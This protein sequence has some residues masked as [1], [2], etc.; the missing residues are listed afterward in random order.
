MTFPTPLPGMPT[1]A[2]PAGKTPMEIAQE[3]ADA[4]P[5][6][7][8]ASAPRWRLRNARSRPPTWPPAVRMK[9]PSWPSSALLK[10]TRANA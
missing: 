2:Y 3:L 5:P 10:R 7:K 1:P 9:P 4:W 6:V 8:R